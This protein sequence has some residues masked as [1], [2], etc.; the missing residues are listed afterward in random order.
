LTRGADAG[1]LEPRRLC[2]GLHEGNAA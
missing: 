1:G 2:F